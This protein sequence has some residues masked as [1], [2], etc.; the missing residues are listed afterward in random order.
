MGQ[1]KSQSLR[2]IRRA[3][4]GNTIWQPHGRR[5]PRATSE[6]PVPGTDPETRCSRACLAGRP[7]PASPAARQASRFRS[8]R[9]VLPRTAAASNNIVSG[10]DPA[11][12]RIN[13]NATKSA[14][15]R[16]DKTFRIGPKRASGRTFFPFTSRGQQ[17]GARR[18]LTAAAGF[19]TP[20]RRDELPRRGA[21][22]FPRLPRQTA[23]EGVP[24]G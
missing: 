3:A 9:R 7:V 18:E 19:R 23:L 6:S 8:R 15:R 24:V 21:P 14:T 10:I 13:L 2:G 22:V 1:A 17:T 5:F 20:D 4:R 11:A 16:R 12:C